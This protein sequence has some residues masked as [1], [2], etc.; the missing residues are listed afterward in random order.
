ME[1]YIYGAGKCGHYVYD[2]IVRCTESNIKI[3][4]W[5]DNDELKKA[6]LP[7]LTEAEFVEIEK[8]HDVAILVAVE[9]KQIM[10]QIVLSL[11]NRGMVNVYVVDEKIYTNHLEVINEQGQF[12]KYIKMYNEVKPY[13]RYVQ[14]AITMHCNLNCRRCAAFANLCD[15]EYADLD[16]FEKTLNGLKHRFSY[17]P[18]IGLLGGEP[19]LNPQLPEF[20]EKVHEILPDTRVRIVTNGLLLLTMDEK[21]IKLLKKYDVYVRITQY[22]VTVNIMSDI[23]SFLEKNGLKHSESC[24]VTEFGRFLHREENREQIGRFCDNGRCIVEKLCYHIYNGRI[25]TC[26]IP[27]DLYLHQKFLGLKITREEVEEVSVDLIDGKEDGWETLM[28]INTIH[29][30]CRYCGVMEN[31]KWSNTGKVCAE[32]YIV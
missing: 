17:I 23:I 22:P 25:C 20:I 19:L 12:G 2:E 5:I 28:K 10:T 7:C 3:L 31:V 32:D 9:N 8:P 11:L 29:E 15:E 21:L 4:G 16:T 30:L 24:L 6:E 1:I 27:F 26:N 13:L 18:S 14:Y